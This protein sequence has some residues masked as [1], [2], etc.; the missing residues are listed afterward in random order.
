MKKAVFTLVFVALKLIA[1]SQTM[2]FYTEIKD[3]EGITWR[4]GDVIETGNGYLCSLRDLTSPI[5]TSKL[6]GLSSNGELFNEKVLAPADTTINLTSLFS[7][8]DGISVA[9]LGIC[10]PPNDT[11]LLLMLCLDNELNVTRRSLS[12]LPMPDHDG[13]RLDDFKFLQ[14][15]D[16]YF[17]MLGYLGQ[18]TE[19]EIKLCKISSEGE[20]IA[21]EKMADSL[22]AYGAT[23]FCAQDDPNGFGLFIGKPNNVGS[24]VTTRALLYDNYLQLKKVSDIAN[25]YE[26]DGHGNVY[27]GN[28]RTF[29]SMILPSPLGGYFVSSRLDQH[30][31]HGTTTEHDRSSVL[32]RTDNDF[33]IQPQYCIIGHFNDTVEVPSFYRSVDV[34]DE[35]FVYQCSMQNVNFGS[36]PFVNEGTH[37]VITKTT[38]DLEMIWQRHCLKNGNVYS[39]FQTL[40]TGDGGCLVVGNVYDHNPEL[41]QDV[42]LLKFNSEGN[43]EEGEL[44]DENWVLNYPNPTEGNFTILG[45][46]LVQ[47]EVFNILGQRTTAARANDTGLALDLTGQ[48]AGI[49]FV[50]ITSQ[51]GKRCVK[52]VIK[53]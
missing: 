4:V 34:N 33:I 25:W 47:A 41:C 24:H 14:V 39:A 51:D 22:V 6:V 44:Q 45:N 17:A 50:S 53:Q 43:H 9:G 31:V 3:F 26:D 40:A 49:Y 5:M 38:M 37:L 46:N 12:P 30:T 23:M 11:A 29:N 8:A 2:G 52:K 27:L 21:V 13:Y 16:G 18:P 7:C 20:L 48:P 19:Q 1:F 36:W 42:F 28:I 10:V 32:A 35:G 15:E